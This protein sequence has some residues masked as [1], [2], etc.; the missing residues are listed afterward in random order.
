LTVLWPG[1][2]QRPVSAGQM[3]AIS[4][5]RNDVPS[6]LASVKQSNDPSVMDTVF[7]YTHGTADTSDDEIVLIL[8]DFTE[9]VD[10][11]MFTVLIP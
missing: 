6:H 4:A 8:E 3:T 5:G 10:I 1:F 11:D 9:P 2:R 7:Y